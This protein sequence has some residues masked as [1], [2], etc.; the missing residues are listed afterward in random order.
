MLFLI[1]K[2]YISE[3]SKL[4][5]SHKLTIATIFKISYPVDGGPD[6]DF[7]YCVNGSMYR[8]FVG[9]NPKRYKIEVGTKYML[10]YYPANPK[11]ARILLDKPI[12]SVLIKAQNLISCP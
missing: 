8:D 6:A 7:Q 2:R 4:Q 9:F 10:K 11:I 12:D 1:I 3:E 5:S